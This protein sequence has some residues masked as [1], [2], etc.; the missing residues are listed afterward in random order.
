MRSR[1]DFNTMSWELSSIPISPRVLVTSFL[2]TGMPDGLCISFSKPGTIL[3]AVRACIE[4]SEIQQ[5]LYDGLN[6][7]GK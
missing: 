2:D 4:I 5:V 3:S 7:Q 1:K 6:E